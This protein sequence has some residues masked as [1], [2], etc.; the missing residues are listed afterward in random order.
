MAKR[1]SFEGYQNEKVASRSN[2]VSD[3]LG[4]LASD[5]RAFSGITELAKTLAPMVYQVEL[6]KYIA[7]VSAGKMPKKKPQK[8]SYTTL[9]RNKK[10]RSLLLTHQTNADG[11]S[12]SDV[13]G[14]LSTVAEQALITSKNIEIES[15]KAQISYLEEE[16]S[17][18][19]DLI[20]ENKR[21][22]GFVEQYYTNPNRNLQ[23]GSESNH[24]ELEAQ[25]ELKRL[26]GQ[27]GEL[28]K[29]ILQ[30]NDKC[31]F[32]EINHDEQTI[33]DLT[34][35]GVKQIVADGDKLNALFEH[36]DLLRT[37]IT[38]AD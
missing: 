33:R 22:K 21:L 30:I 23:I 8:C 14:E 38:T 34:K 36:I 29:V 10:Y 4:V 17:D 3:C 7:S 9:T 13:E 5:K 19:D 31:E 2:I 16:K 32:I 28:V 15:L 12:L 24:G 11:K 6:E 18:E 25:N 35:L 27:V 26:K 1:N 20:A 37:G